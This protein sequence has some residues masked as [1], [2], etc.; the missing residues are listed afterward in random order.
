MKKLDNDP[1]GNKRFD[2]DE[3]FLQYVIREDYELLYLHSYLEDAFA[4]GNYAYLR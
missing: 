4:C 3:M 2:E 1:T